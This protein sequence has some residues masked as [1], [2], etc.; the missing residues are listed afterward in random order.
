MLVIYRGI[1]ICEIF[2]INYFFGQLVDG[3]LNTIRVG[4]GL[5]LNEVG[6]FRVAL[7]APEVEELSLQGLEGIIG[8]LDNF[9]EGNCSF[10]CWGWSFSYRMTVSRL[11]GSHKKRHN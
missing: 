6:Q 10:S 9:V 1:Y 2:I 8:L 3:D 11:R 4:L 7:D 5:G